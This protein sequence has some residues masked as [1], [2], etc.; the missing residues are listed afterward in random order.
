MLEL[1]NSQQDT[2]DQVTGWLLDLK[3]QKELPKD[4]TQA[5][6]I[7][8]EAGTG[9]TFLMKVLLDNM[10]TMGLKCSTIAFTGKAANVLY[11]KTGH[12]SCTIHR[13]I[14]K[15][16]ISNDD[17]Y[18]SDAEEEKQAFEDGKMLAEVMN[19]K[20]II[21]DEY[22][23]LTRE[24]AKDLASLGKWLILVGDL[25]QLP[26]VK[27][28]C[29]SVAEYKKMLNNVYLPVWELKE[30][31]RQAEYNPILTLA[32]KVKDGL[33]T[34]KEYT[35]TH[36]TSSATLRC[37]KTPKMDAKLFGL[38]ENIVVCST[39][40]TRTQLNKQIRK[41][42]G[43]EGSIIAP[44]EKIVIYKNHKAEKLFNGESYIIK[45][46]L[47]IGKHMGFNYASISID[48]GDENYEKV[49]YINIW[50]DPLET[51]DY[52]WKLNTDSEYSKAAQ[53]QFMNSL[54]HVGYGYAITC[55]K[56]QG[57]EWDLVYIYYTDCYYNKKQW[58]YTALTRAKNHAV[59]KI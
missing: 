17:G 54:V 50:L 52:S 3:Q 21:V 53:Y 5:C 19:S 24:I 35:T 45:E 34:L 41:V 23:M 2:L 43:F 31:V 46:V 44:G 40:K 49:K 6:I 29:I 12:P 56:A 13:L 18:F 39:N 7:N 37:S 14:Y 47:K 51:G 9:K 55:H 11:K 4:V 28:A 10:R 36:E 26:P 57:S 25:N 16:S 22:S 27:E 32:R 48:V 15:Y 58:L 38:E 30:P 33:I 42:L 1:T 59:I 8:G 20:V